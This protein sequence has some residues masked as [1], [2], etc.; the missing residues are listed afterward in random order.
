M[1]HSLITVENFSYSYRGTSKKVLK[2]L[3]FSVEEF[4]CCAILGPS[5]AGKTTLCYAIAS[6]LSHYYSGGK[7]AGKIFVDGLDALTAPLELM[8]RRIGF[9]MQN[10]SAYLSDIKPTVREEIAFSMENFGIERSRMIKQTELLMDELGISHLADRSPLELSGGEIQRV[11]LASV[12][13]L[14]PP[15]LILDE[16][17]SSL[18]PDGARDLFLILKRLK[19]KKTMILVEQRMEILPHLVDSLLVLRNGEIAYR[20]KPEQ[21]WGS[22]ILL[23]KDVGAPIWTQIVHEISDRLGKQTGN[24]FTYRQALQS[25]KHLGDVH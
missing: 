14:D 10:S 7:T 1:A 3:T 24:S 11:A 15:I 20:G 8:V 19:G 18:D 5:E 2:D 23:E 25:I 17:T 9:L 16:P 22:P 6:I 21:Y 13:A 4:E 12:M